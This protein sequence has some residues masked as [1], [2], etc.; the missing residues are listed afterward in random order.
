MAD[1][2]SPQLAQEPQA[3]ATPSPA[4]MVHYSGWARLRVDKVET[5][6]DTLSALAK[7]SGGWVERMGGN[8]ITLRVP[9]GDFRA[10]MAEILKMGEVLDKNI[11][12]QDVTEAFLSVELRLQTARGARDRLVA[13]LAKS[14]DENEKLA[15]VREIQRL[16]EEIDRL[17]SQ[18]KTL[19]ALANFSRITVELVPREALA[20][21]GAGAESLTFAW[22]RA[23]SPFNDD[24]VGT[25][26]RLKL[27]VPDGMVELDLKRRFI[28]ESPD[29]ARIWSGKLQSLTLGD[30]AFW[31]SALQ[32]RFGKEFA[33]AEVRTY[34]QLK[35]LRLVDRGDNPYTWLIGVRA[36]GKTL[37]LVEVLF[38]DAAAEARY[39]A[40]V[41]V[42][43]RSLGGDE[44]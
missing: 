44:S 37:H 24:I 22:I 14:E 16:S 18:G 20:W 17:E 11:S 7:A 9:V 32:E 5:A 33:S 39:G 43:L 28:A 34:G 25:G 4:R 12:A 40:A 1:G 8:S 29:G 27:P 30:S 23:L 21:Q 41:E 26:K 10:K 6:T 15:L 42:S 35:V 2:S 13:L 38:P 3:V 31:V 36:E 19:G